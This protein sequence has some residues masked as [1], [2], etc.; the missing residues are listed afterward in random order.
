[1]SAESPAHFDLEMLQEKKQDGSS[2]RMIT[3]LKENSDMSSQIDPSEIDLENTSDIT[4]SNPDGASEV[5]QFKFEAVQNTLKEPVKG[6]PF[7]FQF[8]KFQ[9]P[10]FANIFQTY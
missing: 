7:L 4:L 9:F 5:V 10:N 3:I 2:L 1:M 8:S 6:E